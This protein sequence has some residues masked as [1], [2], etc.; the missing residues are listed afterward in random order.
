MTDQEKKA[1]RAEIA[2]ENG[3]KSKGPVSIAGKY[4]S[5]M[6]AIATGQHVEVHDQDLPAF[7]TILGVDDRREYVRMFQAHLRKFRPDSEHEHFLVR[8]LTAELFQFERTSHIETAAMQMELDAVLREYPDLD[9]EEHLFQS[10]KRAFSQE[11]LLRS[12]ERK[13]KA[14]LHAYERFL[15]LLVKA[16]SEFPLLP[17]EPVDIT[18]DNKVIELPLPA[19]AVVEEMLEQADRAKKEPSFRLPLYVINFL[20]NKEV[21]KKVAPHYDPG[22]LL[23]RYRNV[24]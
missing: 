23:T 14:H 7:V 4:R 13:R 18:A 22:E 19:P 16:R 10:Y 24:K 11:K 2:R 17:P 21:I 5:S 12:L 15:R 20:K 6:N 9:P 1:R 3:R 8:H